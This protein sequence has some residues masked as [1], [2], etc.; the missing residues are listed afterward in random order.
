MVK[1]IVEDVLDVMPAP[2]DAENAAE[3]QPAARTML[4][5]VRQKSRVPAVVKRPNAS[6]V[7][8]EK[9]SHLPALIPGSLGDIDAYIRA[10]N[11][12]PILSAEE[13][14]ELAEALQKKGDLQAAQK[15]IFSHLRLVISV[16][17]G[18]LG[19]GL[20]HSDL[21]QE[22][23]IGLM[24]AIKHYD[25]Q[26]GAR[27]MTYA[28]TW[29]RSEI[30]DYIIKNWRLV[31][32]A[33]TKNQR[34]LFFNLRQMKSNEHALTQKEA[35]DIAATL[36]VKPEEVFDME[37]RMSGGDT[38]LEGTAHSD[39]EES[40]GTGFAPIDWLSRPQDEPEVIL[41]EKSRNRLSRAGLEKALGVLDERS[42]RVIE[43]R[44]LNEDEEGN[45]APLTL[46]VLAKE[47]GVSI[48]RVRQLEKKALLKM[49]E[50]LAGEEDL[51]EE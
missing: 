25:P 11:L 24:K 39:T 45:P 34:K 40:E 21:I 9:K 29:I 33:T 1:R 37:E 10:A 15:L 5:A 28:V 6:L 18:Y 17:R 43:G 38:P 23:N 51:I 27:L 19:Y 32:L 44:Y 22:G 41:E 16:A 30:Q 46:Q 8:Y 36:E 26:K 47:L 2:E 4:P 48:E 13:E 12:A 42:R 31:K 35:N 7:P 20:P 49:R 50:A 14:K 3:A